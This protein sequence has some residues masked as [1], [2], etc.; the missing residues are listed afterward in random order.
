LADTDRHRQT[1]TF[2]HVDRDRKMQKSE[3]DTIQYAPT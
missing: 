3:Y 2:A 1:Q